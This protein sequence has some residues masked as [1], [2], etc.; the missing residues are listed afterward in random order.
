MKT[1]SSCI[2]ILFLAISITFAQSP[3][4]V[5]PANNVWNTAIDQLPVHPSSSSWVSTIGVGKYLHA[6][7]GAGLYGGAS[8]GI[9]YVTVPGSQTMYP[10]TF[11]YAD[12]SDPGPYAVPLGAPIEGGSASSGDRHAI[13]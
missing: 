4:A 13:S 9:P 11:T 8:I 6:D 12:E 3:C 5:F 10:A 1:A 2:C 7:F